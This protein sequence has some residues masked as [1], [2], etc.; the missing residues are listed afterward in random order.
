MADTWV[1]DM[2]HYLDDNGQIPSLPGPAMNIALFLGSIV[3]WMTSEPLANVHHTNVRCRRSPGRARCTGGI[4]AG[5][6]EDGRVI[7]WGCPLCGDNGHIRGWEDTLWDRSSE[8]DG[9]DDP[10][11]VDTA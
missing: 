5:Y 1:T 10:H 2:R 8:I 3:E 7:R 4:L 11:S 9:P 6:E